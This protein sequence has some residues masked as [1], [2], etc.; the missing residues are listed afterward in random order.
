MGTFWRPFVQ[1]GIVYQEKNQQP[2][3]THSNV[4]Y[5]SSPPKISGHI[6]V[7]QSIKISTWWTNWTGFVASPNQIAQHELKNSGNPFY[8]ENFSSCWLWNKQPVWH[9]SSTEFWSRFLFMFN[10]ELDRMFPLQP[11]VK[12][13]LYIYHVR[14]L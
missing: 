3:S 2:S 10:C 6:S 9:L 8:M 4:S 5:S 11:L 1:V 7:N 14:I 12:E 13:I